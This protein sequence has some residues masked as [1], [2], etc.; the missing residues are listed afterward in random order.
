MLMKK[1]QSLSKTD[2]SKIRDPEKL[3]VAIS[4][5]TNMLVEVMHMAQKH[6]I[7]SNLYHGETLTITLVMH[8]LHAFLQIS[9][10]M[11][12][13]RRKRLLKY[14][15]REEKLQTTEVYHQQL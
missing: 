10:R 3:V 2:L 4:S 7:E 13:M 1:I 6:N 9:M 5:L 12:Q 11:N 15:E 8:V 14:L